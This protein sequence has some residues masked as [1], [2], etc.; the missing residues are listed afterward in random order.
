MCS[1]EVKT[2]LFRSYCSSFYTAQLWT[3]FSNNVMNKLFIAYHNTL[4][5][6]IGVNKREHTRPICVSLNVKYCP[7]LI[8]NLV[9]RF[10]KRLMISENL[11]IKTLCQSS[12]FYRSIM[13]K[14]WRSILFTNGI[15]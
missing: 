10:M 9:Y 14:H 4:K 7:A 6:F 12:C 2:T 13:W 5:L 3:K 11:L 1:I 8:R 15:G